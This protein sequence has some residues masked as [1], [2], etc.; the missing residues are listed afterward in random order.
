MGST[1]W[2]LQRA[3]VRTALELPMSRSGVSGGYVV[4]FNYHPKLPLVTGQSVRLCIVQSLTVP[5]ECD[6]SL[7]SGEGAWQRRH[8]QLILCGITRNVSHSCLSVLCSESILPLLQHPQSL[9]STPTLPKLYL[10]LNIPSSIPGICTFLITL[11]NFSSSSEDLV[12]V[13]TAPVTPG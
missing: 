12:T 8:V 5:L 3:V 6:C 7:G 9:S 13:F 11:G 4:V 10:G 1:C 2:L